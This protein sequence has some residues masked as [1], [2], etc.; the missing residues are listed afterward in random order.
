M[1]LNPTTL[2][3]LVAVWIV[4]YLLGLLESAIKNDRKAKKDN[5]EEIPPPENAAKAEPPE[6]PLTPDILEPE[7]L[8]VYQRISGALKLR[9]D[10]ETIEYSADINEGQRKKLLALVVALR[11]WLETKT[12]ENAPK[13]HPA[14]PLKP[15]TKPAPPPAAPAVGAGIDIKT[16]G[17]SIVDQI[18]RILQAKL[19]NSP[20]NKRGIRLRSSLGGGLLIL[21]GLD[22][23]EWV[24]D[25]PEQEIQDVIRE[26]IAEWEEKATP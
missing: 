17:L 25:I 24:D 21:V 15:P 2:G 22:E 9:I 19:E 8:T 7:V 6:S 3:I 10:G 1:E 13:E 12:E 18:D 5:Q 11:P 23:Y 4:G 26:A 14:P 20:L 16:S